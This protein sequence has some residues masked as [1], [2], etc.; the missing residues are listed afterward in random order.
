MD[1]RMEFVIYV[2]YNL[3]VSDFSMIYMF[4]ITLLLIINCVLSIRNTNFTYTQKFLITLISFILVLIHLIIMMYFI[5]VTNIKFEE[6]IKLKLE[7]IKV[8]QEQLEFMYNIK[9]KFEK[10]LENLYKM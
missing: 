2:F 5:N 6:S 4:L 7:K 10:V 9:N 8:S 1:L 3:K